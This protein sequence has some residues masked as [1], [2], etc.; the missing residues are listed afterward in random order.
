MKN[1]LLVVIPAA[2]I[3]QRFNKELPKQYSKLNGKSV[4]EQSVQP[5]LD[6]HLVSKVIIAVSESDSYINNQDFFKN[7]K[8][9]IVHGGNSRAQSVLNALNNVQTEDYTYV[10]THDAARPNILEENIVNIY[11][12]ISSRDR[13]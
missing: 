9:N 10:I 3:G 1:R 2:G 8:I 7:E 6:S 11:E 5:F 4:I 13:L 12:E